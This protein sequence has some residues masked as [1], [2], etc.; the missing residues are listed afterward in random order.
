MFKKILLKIKTSIW[1]YPVMYSVLS[2]IAAVFIIV[3]DSRVLFNAQDYLPSAL[4][5][6]IELAK[7]ILGTIAGS[8]LTMTT[9]TFSITMIVLTMYSSQ[10]SLRTV[11]NFLSDK[12]TMK[13]LGV[14]MGGFV[15]SIFSLLFMRDAI[16]KYMVISASIGVIY[17]IVCLAYFS[18]FINHVGTL[19]QASNLI[20]RLYSESAKKITQYKRLVESGSIRS[21]LNLA[22]YKF[23]FRLT[24]HQNG[25]I[26]LVDH[27]RIQSI[28]KDLCAVIVFEKVIGQFVTDS[29]VIFSIY[30]EDN[31]TIDEE[32]SKKLLSCITIG[33]YRN[34]LQDFDFSIQKIVEIALRA[35][36]PGVNDP[37]T[38]NH[39]IKMLGI[40]L[41]LI[42]DLENGHIVFEDEDGTLNVVFE[43]IDFE[44][45]LYFTFYQIVHYARS[46]VSVLISIFKSLRYAY[47]SAIPE[48]RDKISE[49]AGYVW[50]H[51]DSSLKKGMDYEILKRERDEIDQS[52]F[53][54]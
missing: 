7:T 27:S 19:I 29:T 32:T 15:Y 37:N 49:F 17:S 45:E 20:D 14:F 36:S 5:T 10:F 39:C 26:Q 13:V 16:S 6:S 44:K 43:A 1:L 25:Y 51:M 48:N 28:A 46:D 42:S 9:F 22:D 23:A 11:E 52:P 35:I 8:L 18:I 40:L 21:S 38:A 50:Y 33:N 34:E 12:T 3:I 41:G 53:Y 31:I 54:K 2:L 24:S 47:Q 30:F 4:F